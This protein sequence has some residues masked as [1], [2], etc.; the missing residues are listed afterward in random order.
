LSK[1]KKRQKPS[2][3][4]ASQQQKTPAPERP[5]KQ[6]KKKRQPVLKKRKQANWPLKDSQGPKWY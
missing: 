1:K 6:G 5:V 3:V 4:K 2:S